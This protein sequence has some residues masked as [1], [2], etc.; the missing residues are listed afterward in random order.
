MG[1]VTA[2]W[3]DNRSLVGTADAVEVDVPR[4]RAGQAAARRRIASL[5]PGAGV[6]VC[7][8]GPFP[9]RRVRRLAEATALA[10]DRQYL[11][12]PSAAAPAYLVEDA[13]A[14]IDYFLRH[15]LVA[16]P[17]VRFGP[18]L[19]LVVAALRRFAPVRLVRLA[20]PG[21]VA[22]GRVGP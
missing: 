19:E 17:G 2:R 3:R 21:R 8:S 9:G 4:A 11:A 1:P 7:A 18:A 20:V 6:V 13:P 14:A 12:F 10:L 22:V 16:P 5:E 15:T